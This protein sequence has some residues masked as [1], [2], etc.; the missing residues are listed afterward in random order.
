M[1][2]GG[3]SP[4]LGLEIYSHRPDN[5]GSRHSGRHVMVLTSRAFVSRECPRHVAIRGMYLPSS[6]LAQ[7]VPAAG[8]SSGFQA[9]DRTDSIDFG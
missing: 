6:C 1:P 5:L 8:H 7:R 3:E 9:Y 4:C 2:R